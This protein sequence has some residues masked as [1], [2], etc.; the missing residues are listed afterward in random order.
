MDFFLA[1]Q[2]HF[3][4]D[5]LFFF[6]CVTTKRKTFLNA[7]G[8]ETGQAYAENRLY[9]QRRTARFELGGN[10]QRKGTFSS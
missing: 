2:L 5:R 3:T 10:T 8:A 4:I 9:H 1:V 7:K 6:I